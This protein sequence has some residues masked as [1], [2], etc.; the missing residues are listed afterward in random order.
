LPPPRVISSQTSLTNSPRRPVG[1][2]LAP[3]RAS[4]NAM[5]RP[6]PDVPPTTTATR[7]VKSVMFSAMLFTCSA[8]WLSRLGSRSRHALKTLGGHDLFGPPLTPLTHPLAEVAGEHALDIALDLGARH[9]T[10]ALKQALVG[11]R[12][13]ERLLE[14]GRAVT[15]AEVERD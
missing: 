15:R 6:S 13:H 5:A 2:V 4:P 9:G 11:R 10:P 12:E 7:P 3:A 8:G 1:T 14:S